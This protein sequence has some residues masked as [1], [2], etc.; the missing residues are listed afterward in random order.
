MGNN[1][2]KNSVFDHIFLLKIQIELKFWQLKGNFIFYNFSKNSLV[3][4]LSST[5]P[6]V[7]WNVNLKFATW[8]ARFLSVFQ[9]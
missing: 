7:P 4:I 5:M 9:L 2:L 1:P 6:K 3:R 8:L